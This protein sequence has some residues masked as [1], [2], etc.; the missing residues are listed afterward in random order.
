MSSFDAKGFHDKEDNELRITPTHFLDAQGNPHSI[1]VEFGKKQNTISTEDDN[2]DI[3]DNTVLAKTLANNKLKTTLAVR[4]WNYIKG[5]LGF[6]SSTSRYG[7]SISGTASSAD[8]LVNPSSASSAIIGKENEGGYLSRAYRSSGDNGYPAPYGNVFTIG[9]TGGTQLF[10]AWSG[11]KKGIAKIYYRN[12][13]DVETTD[14][15][16]WSEW[17]ALAWEDH[18]HDGRYYTESEIDTKLSNKQDSL[19][20]G[21]TYQIN[22]SGNAATAE[23]FKSTVSKGNDNK[24]IYVQA[25]EIK[26][27]TYSIVVGSTGNNAN[28]VYIF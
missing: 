28:T 13:R 8:K 4:L 2:S 14:G 12:R 9:G 19:V 10:L 7:I 21:N 5:K 24:A 17:K 3:A 26:E 16:C 15:D 18:T 22:I 11:T 20:S 23:Q 1:E 27:C 6:N 25:G